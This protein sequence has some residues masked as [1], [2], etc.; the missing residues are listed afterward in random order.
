MKTLFDIIDRLT[1]KWDRSLIETTLNQIAAPFYERKLVFFLL[2]EFWDT[3][4]LIDDPLEFMTEERMIAHIEHLLDKERNER[5]AKTVMLE[6][7]ESP[8]FKVTVMNVDELI[9][10]HSGWF[11]KYDGTT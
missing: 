9:S 7:I 4:E 11:E 10:Q 2:E 6:V 8:D 5:A 1:M 3:L